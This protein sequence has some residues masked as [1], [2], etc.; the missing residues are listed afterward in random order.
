MTSGTGAGDGNAAKRVA[1]TSP[2]PWMVEFDAGAETDPELQNDEE[3]EWA[4]YVG[5]MRA[6]A[7]PEA[8]GRELRGA[9]ALEQSLAAVVAAMLAKADQTE[10]DLD[11]DGTAFVRS[12][13]YELKGRGARDSARCLHIA[14]E[15][16]RL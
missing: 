2:G 4:D 9:M 14:A 1:T 16:A 7:E 3:K 5:Q 11:M 15:L 6:E 13:A 12:E 8:V 10:R